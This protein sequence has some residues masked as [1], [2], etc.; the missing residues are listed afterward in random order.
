MDDLKQIFEASVSTR[1]LF[2]D[3]ADQFIDHVRIKLLRQNIIIKDVSVT[4]IKTDKTKGILKIGTHELVRENKVFDLLD[5]LGVYWYRWKR[6]DDFLYLLVDSRKLK[7]W[8][9][10]LLGFDDIFILEKYLS[11]EGSYG[12][13]LLFLGAAFINALMLLISCSFVVDSI[14]HLQLISKTFFVPF[15]LSIFLWLSFKKLV[16]L[17][18]KA[19]LL[20]PGGTF[21]S[22]NGTNIRKFKSIQTLSQIELLNVFF[23]YIAFICKDLYHLAK[24]ERNVSCIKDELV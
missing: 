24:S 10:R 16:R 11:R 18:H 9:S 22:L 17:A 23:L 19:F 8:S 4:L 1:S 3:S 15:F 6:E 7:S 21:P 12:A 13:F 5:I 2:G 20:S 14:F